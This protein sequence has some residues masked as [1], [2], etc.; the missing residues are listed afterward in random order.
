[1]KNSRHLVENTISFLL[2][3]FI[4]FAVTSNTIVKPKTKVTPELWSIE[5][6]QMLLL[7]GFASHNYLILRDGNG[8]V[9]KELH[10]T[11]TEKDGRFMKVSLLPGRTLRVMEFSE[12]LNNAKTYRPSAITVY[13]GT[14]EDVK[15]K[16]LEGKACAKK[17]NKENLP[18]PALGIQLEQDTIN[19]NSVATTLLS[20]MNLPSPRVGLF[21]PGSNNL[22]MR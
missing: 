12:P 6:A 2:F 16:W 20:C 10:G 21:T 7:F 15:G 5:K 3:I 14:K 22:I 13:T 19:S 9:E 17:I 18:Y 8:F 1:M 4:Y 11:P